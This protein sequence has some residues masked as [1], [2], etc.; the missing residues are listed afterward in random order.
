MTLDHG[1]RSSCDT[2]FYQV[3]SAST[4]RDGAPAPGVGRRG[5]RRA[6]RHR[7]RPRGGRPRPDARVAA[8]ATSRSEID[9]I[10]KTR[11]LDP[12]RD[13]PGRPDRHAAADGALLRDVANGGKLVEPHIVKAVEEPRHAG[14]P[15]VVLRRTRRSRPRTSARPDRAPRR[16][17]GALRGD[18]RELRD[19]GR[20]LRQLPGRGRRQDGHRGEVVRLPGY[21][22]P[23]RTSPGGAATGRTA[24]PEDRVCALIEN[25]GHGGTAAAPAAL[26]VFEQYFHATR[27]VRAPRIGDSRLMAD[28]AATPAPHR[29]DA[30]AEVGAFLAPPRLPDARRGPACRLR[31][32]VLAGDHAQR[33]RRATRATTSSRQERLVAVGV[34]GL[35]GRDR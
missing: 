3:A 21:Q 18:A 10:W 2:Y 26:K 28:H 23:A 9:K 6:D 31:A 14:Q 4:S 24:K 7:R 25:G 12:A 20:H 16:P 13:R 15:P 27:A 32:L 35:R 19:V 11:R 8:G 34:V 17:G 1:D 33:H 30:G 5:L 29:A 22:R